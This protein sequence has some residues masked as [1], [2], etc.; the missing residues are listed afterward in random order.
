MAEHLAPSVLVSTTDAESHDVA[1]NLRYIV[2]CMALVYLNV[3]APMLVA[4]YSVWFYGRCAACDTVFSI[5]SIAGIKNMS[6]LP[7]ALAG[8]AVNLLLGAFAT[9]IILLND[10]YAQNLFVWGAGDLGQNGFGNKCCG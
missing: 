9:A 3:V 6:G 10:Q 8:M 4:Q 5:V 7:P 1:A 2:R